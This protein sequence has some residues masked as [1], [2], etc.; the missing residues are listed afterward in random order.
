MGKY[1]EEAKELAELFNSCHGVTTL[2]LVPVSNMFHVHF[3]QAKEQVASVLTEVQQTTGIGFTSYLA[4]IDE[5]T[6]YYEVSLGDLYAEVPKEEVTKA[7]RLL[8]EKM[9]Q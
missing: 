7:F 9:K 4:E 2:P 5:K 3:H 6:C 8:D 1:F